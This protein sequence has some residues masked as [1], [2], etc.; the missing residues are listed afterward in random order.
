MEFSL[1]RFETIV[2]SGWIAQ[3]RPAENKTSSKLL[4]MLHGWTGDENSMGIFTKGLDPN[5]HIIAP[6]APFEAIPSGYSWVEPI[7]DYGFPNWGLFLP[8]AS[9]LIEQINNWRILLSVE[10]LTN[11]MLLGFSQGAA[12]SLVLGIGYPSLFSRVAAISGFLPKNGILSKEFPDMPRFYIA[13]G[14]NDEIVSV[15]ESHQTVNYLN[16]IGANVTYCESDAK[17]RMSLRCLPGLQV[18]LETS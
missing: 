2:D 18:F 4:V 1:Q 8:S 16:T 17:H 14:V 6:R 13:H 15:E 10:P 11:T 7:A 3:Y 9:K 12:M 5:T